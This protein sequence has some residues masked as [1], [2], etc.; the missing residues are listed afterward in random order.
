MRTD[1]RLFMWGQGTAQT[2]L[3]LDSR[4][5]PASR[6]VASSGSTGSSSGYSM[7]ITPPT[8]TS[9]PARGITSEDFNRHPPSSS[10]IATRFA[11]APFTENPCSYAYLRDLLKTDYQEVFA[12]VRRNRLR[13]DNHPVRFMTS[14]S[15]GCH[16]Q[17]LSSSISP[18][19]GRHPRLPVGLGRYLR[20]LAPGSAGFRRPPWETCVSWP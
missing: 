6:Y 14:Q 7:S 15:R 13:K 1:D 8:I 9:S 18:R 20:E 16:D 5:R 11:T 17:R 12:R 2:G 19:S 3:Y 10:S 4:R